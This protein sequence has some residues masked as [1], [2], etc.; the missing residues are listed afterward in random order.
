VKD[1]HFFFETFT[2]E[3]QMRINHVHTITTDHVF[4]LI[5]SQLSQCYDDL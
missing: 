4:L 2:L 3:D 1:E 5:F